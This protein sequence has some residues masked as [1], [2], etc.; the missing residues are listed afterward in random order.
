MGLAGV[1]IALWP[2][3]TQKPLIHGQD[4]TLRGTRKK[5]RK[6]LEREPRTFLKAETYRGLLQ[7]EGA[8]GLA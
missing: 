8:L 2:G 5:E 7:R 6:E 3:N 4:Q 1:T